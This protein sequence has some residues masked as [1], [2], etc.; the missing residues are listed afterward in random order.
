MAPASALAYVG[1][2]SAPTWWMAASRAT[3][4]G[5]PVTVNW[6][7]VTSMPAARTTWQSRTTGLTSPYRWAVDPRGGSRRSSG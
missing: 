7:P 4:N 5:S 6:V 1:R 2:A 3:V